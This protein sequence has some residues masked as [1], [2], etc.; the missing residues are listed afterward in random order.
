MTINYENVTIFLFAI[1]LLFNYEHDTFFL[2]NIYLQK[3]YYL[4]FIYFLF[5]CYKKKEKRTYK[6]ARMDLSINIYNI[7]TILFKL[8]CLGIS[9]FH[10]KFQILNSK[11]WKYLGQEARP[12]NNA[13]KVWE[14]NEAEPC[15]WLSRRQLFRASRSSLLTHFLLIF[16]P[17][18]TPWSS[19]PSYFP[20]SFQLSMEFSN[21][22][23]RKY[24]DDR[25]RLLEFLLSSGLIKEIRTPAGP[26]TSF[27][28]INFDSI[29]VDYV[30]ECINSGI[31]VFF[32]QK[33]GYFLFP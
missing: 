23:L 28:S 6:H 15:S 14:R 18:L 7:N 33:R 8:K 24:R 10:V 21:P 20:L 25:R 5:F 12:K 9:L 22:M 30:I 26:T 31:Y 16:L 29:S 11:V 13:Q 27:S 2:V 32:L 19:F 3:Y 1:W 17:L 4:L